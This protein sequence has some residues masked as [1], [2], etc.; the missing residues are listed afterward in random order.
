MKQANQLLEIV[1]HWLHKHDTIVR[2][3]FL[4]NSCFEIQ[5]RF[6]NLTVLGVS[7]TKRASALVAAFNKITIEFSFLC[8]SSDSDNGLDGC[9]LVVLSWL[10]INDDMMTYFV[11]A[12]GWNSC[13]YLAERE[14]HPGG[15]ITAGLWHLSRKSCEKTTLLTHYPASCCTWDHHDSDFVPRTTASGLFLLS[16]HKEN[17]DKLW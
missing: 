14:S 13:R 5:R 15:H 2:W 16:Q 3:R 17:P 10:S 8:K 1:S 4:S 9:T 11:D 7:W 6:E 12:L